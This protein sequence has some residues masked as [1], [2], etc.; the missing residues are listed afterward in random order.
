M[1]A[2]FVIFFVS[3]LSV[4]GRL[5]CINV[6]IG[7]IL[8]ADDRRMFSIKHATLA[9]EYAVESLKNNTDYLRDH[10]LSFS[11]GD[12]K[13]SP[14]YGMDEAI[15]FHIN[16]KVDLLLGPVCDYSLAPVARQAM[17]WNLPI[18]TVGGLAQ[19][20]NDHRQSEYALLSRVGLVT[21]NAVTVA[22]LK[23][24]KFFNWN[25]FK[26]IYDK[27]GQVEYMDSFCYLQSLALHYFSKTSDQN[28]TQDYFMMTG[29]IGQF[30]KSEVGLSY[31]GK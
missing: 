2:V 4:F 13:C 24:I 6:K 8:P 26:I 16:M 3:L 12:S 14:V 29:D 28:I 9:I 1:W 22:Y 27:D 10:T 18:I 21:V 20:F 31:S 11:Y 17:V 30:L 15:K 19:D 7:A 25:K 5:E 23:M